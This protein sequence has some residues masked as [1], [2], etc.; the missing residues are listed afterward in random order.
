MINNN[1]ALRRRAPRNL[2]SCLNVADLRQLAYRKLPLPIFHYL[3]G[4][5]EDE[6]SV[7]R[8]TAAFDDY[9]LLPEA[10]HSGSNI[11]LTTRLLGREVSMPLML[12]PTA[13]TRLFHTS[14]EPAV[15]AAAARAGIYFSMSTLATTTLEQ[16]AALCSGPK[17][18]QIYIFRDRGLTTELAARC[19]AA[20]YDALCLTIDTV[21]GANRERDRATGMA[22]PPRFNWRGL[23]Q[24]GQR[25]Q[26]TLQYL[27]GPKFTV[28]NVAHRATTQSTMSIIEYTNSQFDPNLSW[29]DV[30]WLAQHWSGPLIV[31]GVQSVTDAKNAVAA[32]ATALMISNHGGRQ[33]DSTLAPI[34]LLPRIRD[35]VGNTIEL[36]VD[37]GVRRGSHVAKALALGANA[38]SMGRPYLFGLAAGGEAG[39]DWVLKT[40]RDEL[41]RVM[42]L[43]GCATVQQLSMHHVER[44]HTPA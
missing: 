20:H 33:L 9:A 23:L 24:F 15:A 12:S 41:H 16:I 27:L 42:A 43:M 10:L 31:K 29:D 22:F 38:C 6:I 11:N 14:A 18:F 7:R 28:A 34:E 44:L 39:V 3:D 13:L 35:A 2:A 19:K 36:I 40:L 26:W 30:R 4:G 21:V 1:L 25:P 32:G 17:L 8:N 5:A 37:G